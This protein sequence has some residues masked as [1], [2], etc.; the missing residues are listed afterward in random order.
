MLTTS[1][2]FILSLSFIKSLFAH[3]SYKYA[4]SFSCKRGIDE[5]VERKIEV[6]KRATTS[7]LTTTTRP[8]L[9]LGHEMTFAF[10]D[11]HIN[12]CSEA[13]HDY[14][15]DIKTNK[16]PLIIDNGSYQCR[17]GWAT[18]DNPR[19]IFR[20]LVAKQRS[21]KDVINETYIGNDIT[22]IEVVRW[23]L[24]NHF[25]RDVVVNYDLQ[26][27]VF[28]HVFSHL[29]IEGQGSLE[30]P[31]VL[32]EAVC[33]PNHS[34][35]LM[36]ELLF[37][38]YRVPSVSLGVDAL[39]SLYNNRPESM[40][41]DGII[42]SSGYQTSH[43]LPFVNGKLDVTQCRRINVGG[44][45]SVAFLHRLLQLKYHRHFAAINL[46]RSE[47]MLKEH[48]YIAEEFC[49]NLELWSKQ[50]YYNEHVH[51][52]QLPYTPLPG[53]S[54]G[55]KIEQ[56]KQKVE[57]LKELNAKRRQEKL[58]ADQE[59]LKQ[60]LEALTA[61]HED[62]DDDDDSRFKLIEELGFSNEDEILLA[63][64]K[65]KASIRKAKDKMNDTETCEGT[66]YDLLGISDEK[67]TMEMQEKKKRQQV[68]K[69]IQET[70]TKRV[71][72]EVRNRM[73]EGLKLLEE[74]REEEFQEWLQ[75]VKSVKQEIVDKR[76][77]RHQKRSKQAKRGTLEAQERMKRLA[78]LAQDT[79]KKEDTFGMNDDDW[80]VYKQ[81]S[82]DGDDSDSEEEQEKLME[83]EQ[84]LQDFDP[85]YEKESNIS[86]SHFN[87]AE[88]Y[89]LH[90]GTERI[91]APEILFQP[92]MI[93][94]EQGGLAE[95]LQFV[96]SKYSPEVQN[97]LVQNVFITGGNMSY[98]GIEQ[99][100]TKELLEMRPF[101]STFN[102]LKAADPVLDPW[103]GAKKW[104]SDSDQL[105]SGS[106][107]RAEYEEKGMDY[108][109]EHIASNIYSPN[110]K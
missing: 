110:L 77:T 16:V 105:I 63:V 1:L 48:C 24:K 100:I 47:E 55:D 30:H 79:K 41:F 82:R 40:K 75:N 39:Y 98:P 4:A 57:R 67:L 8:G 61:L 65:L 50:N 38:C 95:T 93:G 43:V 28:D 78:Q 101:Q 36:N 68:M 62:E 83:L 103:Y 97:R 87:L 94:L 72:E 34:R 29:G 109:K 104:A 23:M 17:A 13:E 3:H 74:N 86:S 85:S 46:S 102:I 6:N 12:L 19:L 20:N 66:D 18:E 90:L 76:T 53:W 25:D 91:R 58:T 54:T 32:M 99:R 10:K 60:L 64:G 106:C 7:L 5:R 88:Y 108:L 84:L 31:I 15:V 71:K 27:Q 70:L 56:R 69:T 92:S 59:K 44:S 80:D 35:Q 21:K 33:N 42:L 11:K 49:S 89:Q 51:K 26:E 52:M 96:L 14:T 45:Q 73:E 107:S 81:V 9:E 37:E 22:N 2:L